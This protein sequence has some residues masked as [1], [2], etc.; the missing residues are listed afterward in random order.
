MRR[1][2][3]FAL[4]IG[5]VCLPGAE[6]RAVEVIALGVGANANQIVRFDS[7]SPGTIVGPTAVTGL[8][9]GDSLVAVDSRPATG[10]LFGLAVNGNTARLY[11]IDAGSGAAESIGSATVNSITAA[12]SYGIDFDPTVD[13]LRVVNNLASDG[14]GGNANNFR[15]HPD[16]GALVTV[17]PDLDFTPLPGGN[18]NAPSIAVA[19]SNNVDG[20]ATTVLFGAL[21]GGDRLAI[22]GGA[23]PGF[24]TLQNVGPLGVDTSNNAGFD[25]GGSPELGFALFEAGGT[26]QFYRIDLTSGAATLVGQVG[27]GTIDFGGMS[28]AIPTPVLR[29]VELVCGRGPSSAA[30]AAASARIT[31]DAPETSADC[32]KL[33]QKWTSTCRGLVGA[34]R[35]CWKRVGKRVA[36]L[37]SADCHTLDDPA[38]R[39]ACRDALDAEKD[40]LAAFLAAD[41]ESGLVFC[42]GTGLAQCLLNCG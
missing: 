23:A 36:A 40:E 14:V 17:D 3:T 9:P 35:S 5:I 29:A 13:R 4:P 27:S 37:R 33:C 42:S 31:P 22:H 15:L 12:T 8:L 21:S 34:A 38:A 30:A 19:Y 16:T 41:G 6:A 39:D 11:R 25:I 7:A 18:A 2:L 32:P 20:A 10:E 28:V 24:P 1:M 26:S